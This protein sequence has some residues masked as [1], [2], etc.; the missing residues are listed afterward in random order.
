M[1][2]PA[3]TEAYSPKEELANALSHGLGILAGIGGMIYLFTNYLIKNV[4]IFILG[5][6]ISY[7]RIRN[8]SY[9]SF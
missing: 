3:T 1:K 5:L 2:K 8:P 7:L 4:F 9:N 6:I